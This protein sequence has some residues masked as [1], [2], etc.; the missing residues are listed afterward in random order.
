M[1]RWL[2]QIDARVLSLVLLVASPF[3]RADGGCGASNECS[4]LA[5]ASASFLIK[6]SSC[7]VT[8]SLKLSAV[9]GSC[10]VA[11][12]LPANSGLPTSGNRSTSSFNGPGWYLYGSRDGQAIRCNA[13]SSAAGIELSCESEGGYACAAEL[14]REP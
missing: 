4:E 13:Q 6:S 11:V 2:N 9:E 7:G 1:T 14:Q 12:T 3:L 8:G 10:G 5:T